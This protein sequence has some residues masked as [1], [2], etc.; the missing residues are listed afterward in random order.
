[1]SLSVHPARLDTLCVGSSDGILSTFD[2]RRS[3]TALLSMNHKRGI[4]NCAFLPFDPAT[5]LVA[6]DEGSLTAYDFN[7]AHRD[8]TQVR[9]D[10]RDDDHSEAFPPASVNVHQSTLKFGLNALDVDRSSH[11]IAAAGDAM[12]IVHFL[13]SLT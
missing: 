10:G 4:L 6:D 3:D 5:I 12:K 1:L 9:F 2:L 11:A 7:S 8:P 13:Y